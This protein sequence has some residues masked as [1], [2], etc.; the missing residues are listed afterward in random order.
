MAEFLPAFESMILHEGGYIL[1]D[2][3]GDRG[4]QTYAGISRKNWPRWP[5]WAVLDAGGDPP[6]HEVREFYRSSFW[7]PLRLDL[8][9]HQ[10]VART[11]FDFAV[12]AGTGT[13]AKLAQLV[14]G[15]TPDGKI[16]PKS[17]EAINAMTPEVFV[18]RYTLAKL[19]RYEQIVRRDR[20][21]SKFLLGWLSRA[22][23]EAAV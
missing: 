6:V 14:A 3:P 12:N 15:A 2:V 1:H 9:E 13:A 8:V 17:L 4:G 11:L 23:K 20:T 10:A 21:Q 22:L 5:G 18:L 19:S 7:A 16:G